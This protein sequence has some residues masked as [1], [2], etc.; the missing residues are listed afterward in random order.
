MAA[1]PVGFSW[2]KPPYGY[3]KRSAASARARTAP[4]NTSK[5]RTNNLFRAMFLS[6]VKGDRFLSVN[7]KNP[8]LRQMLP[9]APTR[10]VKLH[11]FP[12]PWKRGQP[13][14]TCQR[15][16]FSDALET[17]LLGACVLSK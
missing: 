3:S 13:R 8:F 10:R 16:N 14:I 12:L 9:P 1:C 6:S 15:R 5:Q 11:R 7:I 17:S 4:A 2:P